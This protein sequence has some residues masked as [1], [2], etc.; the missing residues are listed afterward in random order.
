MKCFLALVVLVSLLSGCDSNVVP[1]GTGAMPQLKAFESDQELRDYISD[2]IGSRG[3]EGVV[4]PVMDRGGDGDFAFSDDEATAGIAVDQAI[5]APVPVLPGAG[6]VGGSSSS[7]SAD[8]AGL[9]APPVPEGGPGFSQTTTQEL[10]VDEADVVKTD[11]TYLYIV[12]H[13]MLR[14]V[15]A[16]SL[17]QL[18]LISQVE[19]PGRTRELYLAG[20]RAVVLTEMHGGFF[21]PFIEVDRP[22][23]LFEGDAVSIDLGGPSEEE[24]SDVTDAEIGVGDVAVD[25]APV[26]LG[27]DGF[28]GHYERPWIQATIVDISDVA[29]PEIVSTTRF[30]GS[31][32]SSRMIDGELHL[33]LA[34]RRH[35]FTELMPAMGMSVGRLAGGEVSGDDVAQLLPSFTQVDAQGRETS[36][37][38]LTWEELYR[39]EAPDGFGVVSIVS[40]KAAAPAEFKAVGVVAEPGLIYSSPEALY[41]TNTEYDFSGDARETTEIFKFAY[42]PDGPVPVAAG[43]VV[44]RVLNQYSMSEHNGYLRMAT[45]VGRRFGRFGQTNVS[46]NNVFVLD[47]VG[48]AMRLAGSIE[49]IAPNETIQSARFVG[50]RGFLVT[51]EQ[52]DPLFTLDLSDPTAPVVVGELKVPGFSTF[53]VPMDENHLLAVG[54]YIPDDGFFF[55]RGVQLSIFD[56][57]DFANPVLKHLEV[58]GGES[59]AYSEALH[60]PKAFTYFAEQGLVALPVSIHERRFFGPGFIEEP[61]DLDFEDAADLGGQT[62]AGD[63]GDSSGA[64]VTDAIVARPLDDVVIPDFIAPQGFDGLL[65]YSVSAEAGFEELGRMSMRFQEGDRYFFPSFTRGIFLDDLVLGVTDNAVRAASIDAIV[66]T[67][68]QLILGDPSLTFLDEGGLARP[69]VRDPAGEGQEPADGSGVDL[70]EPSQTGLVGDGRAGDAADSS[71]DPGEGAGTDADGGGEPAT[72]TDFASG[73][74]TRNGAGQDAIAP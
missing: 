3:V 44:G 49:N 16:D 17:D 74:A 55:A 6:V 72:G 26:P 14:I 7:L 19:V 58:I 46:S 62:D 68:T 12:S 36:G 73:G 47:Q 59:G 22:M 60:N 25:V 1:D 37:P 4:M 61:F 50:D 63:S 52:I 34:S 9:E 42:T 69:P 39:P 24:D 43:V 64:P 54:E 33:V 13:G 70:G 20:D 21:L 56:I 23:V 53:L 10:G 18:G 11:G 27:F 15:R 48:A 41:L 2:Q 66:P 30:D 45:T 31:M 32:S 67:Q 51:F 28:A 35:E 71:N 5:G 29:A 57:T 40:M 8:G 65:V 38:L